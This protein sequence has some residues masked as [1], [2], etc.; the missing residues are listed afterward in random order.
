[1][2]YDCAFG[3]LGY[4]GPLKPLRGC[5]SHTPI[6]TYNN[7]SIILSAKY[8]HFNISLPASSS[9]VYDTKCPPCPAECTQ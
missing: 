4:G 2:I 1:M 8:N 6:N 5:L 7:P 9:E 3:C